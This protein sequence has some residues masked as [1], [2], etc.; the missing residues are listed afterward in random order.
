MTIKDQ[1]LFL[2]NLDLETANQIDYKTVQELF[3]YL[4]AIP[5]ADYFRCDT[6]KSKK[7]DLKEAKRLT[8]SMIIN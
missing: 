1:V 2:G 6:R 7:N 4:R 5:D 3:D 8:I